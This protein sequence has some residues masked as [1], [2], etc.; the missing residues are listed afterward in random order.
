MSLS[1]SFS[2]LKNAI[3]PG[4]N[5]NQVRHDSHGAW[6]YRRLAVEN[7]PKSHFM[8]RDGLMGF[9]IWWILWHLYHQPGHIVGEYDYPDPSKWTDAELGI[10]PDD[11]E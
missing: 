7:V 4:R 2:L 3:A 1:R 9:G 8:I 5:W 6:T 10:P 11:E